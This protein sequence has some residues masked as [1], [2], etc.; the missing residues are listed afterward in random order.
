M[1]TRRRLAGPLLAA[2][3]SSS[4]T[5]MLGQMKAQLSGA[6]RGTLMCDGYERDD[7]VH[8][9]GSIAG[10]LGLRYVL[11]AKEEGS[12]HHGLAAAS[13]ISGVLDRLK[14]DG[15]AIGAVW[16][17]DAGQCG[18]A[19][20]I[21][22][23]RYPS[24][25]FLRCMAHQM[26]LLM[27]HV[28]LDTSLG[29]TI[30]AAVAAALTITRSSAKLLPLAKAST[31]RI[32][33]S[34]L[35]I[36]TVCETRRSP[37]QM[38]LASLLR[39]RGA[40]LCFATE[41]GSAAPLALAPLRQEIFWR[42]LELAE[43]IVRPLAHATFI[44]KRDD[45]SLA[46]AFFVYGGIFQHLESMKHRTGISGFYHNLERRWMSEEQPLFVLAFCVHPRYMKMAR[47]LLD[48]DRRGT[49]V[50]HF[51]SPCLSNAAA[52]YYL[53][54]FPGDSAAASAVVQQLFDFLTDDAVRRNYLRQVF[55][56]QN[57]GDH[58]WPWF[59][60]WS[61]VEKTGRCIE[62]ARLAITLLACKLQTASVERL[63]KEWG[64]QATENRNRMALSTMTALTRIKY[65]HED[66][67]RQAGTGRSRTTNRVINAEE[68][69]R[70][71]A[72]ASPL[73]LGGASVP[74]DADDTDEDEPSGAAANTLGEWAASL[75][76]V[77][78][79]PSEDTASDGCPS[80][81][82]FDFKGPEMPELAQPLPTEDVRGYP[83]EVLG[84]LSNFRAAKF[85]LLHLLGR[86]AGGGYSVDLRDHE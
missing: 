13:A 63:F 52:G 5:R 15:L 30:K 55:E 83:Q 37:L 2:A 58:G 59:K 74:A 26:N 16:T 45:T 11:E 17:D 31:Q 49:P 8:V 29:P 39:V 75:N 78:E 77:E 51:S 6:L 34:T 76:Q 66:S 3:A 60:F 27:K 69:P 80:F 67:K 50:A 70:T 22:A 84:T 53:K 35:A 54:W 1:P 12:A 18:R 36:L 43:A 56:G 65:E 21:L 32:Y 61:F 79:D 28:L 4:Q 81:M 20:R 41:V 23:L 48:V 86:T 10:V 82:S 38:C 14:S 42:K 7:R 9:M 40:L 72:Q 44:L 64:A 46:D 73:P 47:A 68:R 57:Q 25:V 71:T 19:R 24:L 33:G 85:S 62:L